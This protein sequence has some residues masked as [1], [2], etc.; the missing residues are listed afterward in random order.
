MAALVLSHCAK[1]H[2]RAQWE[3]MW[4]LKV[5]LFRRNGC[6]LLASRQQVGAVAIHHLQGDLRHTINRNAFNA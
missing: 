6:L 5:A 3:L 4:L 1:R 2:T